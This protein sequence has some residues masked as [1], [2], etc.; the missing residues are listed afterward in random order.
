MPKE[1]ISKVDAAGARIFIVEDESIVARDIRQ[2]LESFGY[3]VVGHSRTAEQALIEIE[4]VKPSLILMDI[5][6]GGAIDG[7]QAATIIRAGLGPP[8]VFVSAFNAD[9]VIE[10]AKLTE[11]YGYIIKPFSGRELRTTVEMALYKYHTEALLREREFQLTQTFETSPICMALIAMDGNIIR[12]NN[13]LCNLLGQDKIE[14]HEIDV[15][16][17]FPNNSEVIKANMVSLQE[18]DRP[19]IRFELSL[20]HQNGLIV[21]L[22]CYL[23][24]VKNRQNTPIHFVLKCQDISEKKYA[25]NQL[26]KFRSAIE[27]STQHIFITDKDAKIEY[28][29]AAMLKVYGYT[30]EEIVGQ[31]P[32]MFSAG[33][34]NA[35]SFADMWSKLA[36]TEVWTGEL[37][38]QRKDGSQLITA[39]IVSPLR[40]EDGL[41]S[42][43]VWVQTDITQQ[44]Q[45]NAELDKH[46]YRMEE[47]VM[48]RT[49]ALEKASEVAEA[50][51]KAKSAFIANMSHEIRTPMNGVLGMTYLAL[52]ATN[53]PKIR[54]YLQKIEISGQHLLHIVDDILDFSKIE[55]GKLALESLD[56]SLDLLLAEMK[57]M[58]GGK[59]AGRDLTLR[60]DIDAA[61]PKQVCGDPYRLKQILLN[62]TNNAIK[63]TERGEINL[64][65]RLLNCTASGWLLRF[66]VE[67]TGIGMSKDQ[68]T[69]L[70][71][72]FEQVDSTMTRKYGGTGLGLVICKELA[73][74]M[75]G[76]VGVLSTPGIGSTFWF[77]AHLQHP[78]ETRLSDR[79]PVDR[80]TA[81][82][83]LKQLNQERTPLRILVVEDNEFNL[84]IATE[85]LEEVDCCVICAENGQ[86]AVDLLRLEM[87]DCVLMDI[88]MP[89][90]GGLEAS[91]ILRSDERFSALPIIAITANAMHQ[92][93][94]QCLSSGMSDFIAKPFAP[95]LFYATILRWFDKDFLNSRA[96]FDDVKVQAESCGAGEMA[97]MDDIDFSVL[98]GHF[99]TAPQK[100]L[101]YAD[102]FVNSARKGLLDLEAAKTS[103]DMEQM[104]ALGHS[105]KSSARTV[106]A[107]GFADLCHALEGLKGSQKKIEAE[108][109]V[110]QLPL[111]LRRIEQQVDRYRQSVST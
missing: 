1:L 87:V 101:I 52:N 84:Q 16:Q 2:Q 23:N 63:F 36:Q 102:K 57:T 100:I 64:F 71:K 43:Y 111:I 38:N 35:D 77:T 97:E 65:V 94:L 95:E 80:R 40:A 48:S 86:V 54:D 8:V 90:M 42:Q 69:K 107:N 85:L 79:T 103:Q 62:Y 75:G 91:R 82:A 21:C 60:F 51:N 105:L 39:A 98:A 53:D 32:Q 89:V 29:N 96:S 26:I 61:V 56:F 4:Q 55:A 88:Q 70:F 22:Q 12:V 74:L 5:M 44:R 41:I 19:T 17:L 20:K 3:Q 67:D 59:V 28:V 18:S 30:S 7:I 10:R 78:S 31:H 45:L 24:I 9:E 76:E 11:P 83:R 14:T 46:R 15:D 106:G 33:E 66:E 6:L 81:A 104:A 27:Q 49:R 92:D 58:L 99:P 50:A 47:M 110:D 108:R 109:I 73:T 25:E 72:S 34:D 37:S 93:R 68:Q 13:S